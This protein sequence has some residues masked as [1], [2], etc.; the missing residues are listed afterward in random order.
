[1][2]QEVD[3]FDS[4]DCVLIT[5]ATGQDGQIAS[6]LLLSLG[7]KVIGLT[8]T[9]RSA[10]S[11]NHPI[12]H[13]EYWDWQDQP[14]LEQVLEKTRPQA[15]LHFAA[16]HHPSTASPQDLLADDQ[17]IIQTNISATSALIFAIQ[18]ASPETQL[19]A[20]ASSQVYTPHRPATYVDESSK[21]QPANLYG[22]T[23]ASVLHM[24]NHYRD[25]NRLRGGSAILFNHES[26]YRP[27]RFVTRMISKA[28]AEIA[29]GSTE[30]LALNN[31]GVAADWFAAED[32]V[33]AMLL[34]AENDR[35]CD[36]IIGSGHSTS[37]KELLHAAFSAV[38][39][40]WQ[41]YVDSRLDE[42]QP[43]L[44]SKPARLCS[45]CGWIPSK[46]IETV[47]QEMVLHDQSL[48]SG[49]PKE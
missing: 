7:K 37:L 40:D 16:H 45:E 17:N 20:A 8:R 18:R 11:E 24:I 48:L 34:M 47:M 4:L 15:V 26:P 30:R 33:R 9:G 1:M 35:G 25:T 31:V 36:F 2:S 19:I 21:I 43:Y 23:K 13:W 32:A 49:S 3:S 39:L 27:Q 46:T 5:G 28:V 14:A 38:D 44:I 29:A 22:V 10:P 42:I 6:E 12:D 41:D